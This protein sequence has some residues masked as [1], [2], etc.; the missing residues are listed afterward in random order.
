M[1]VV[2]LKAFLISF[3][4]FGSGYFLSFINYILLPTVYIIQEGESYFEDLSVSQRIKEYLLLWIGYFYSTLLYYFA[5]IQGFFTWFLPQNHWK[6]TE[7]S[8]A[9]STDSLNRK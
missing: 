9:I 1:I 7:H 3:R 5:Q 2:L 8:S 4:Y 6:K